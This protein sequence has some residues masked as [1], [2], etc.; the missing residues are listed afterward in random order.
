MTAVQAEDRKLQV[1]LPN[2]IDARGVIRYS[3][4]GI[5]VANL[6]EIVSGALGEK[7]AGCVC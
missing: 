7:T 2:L 3:S 6:K 4:H 1:E 5:S